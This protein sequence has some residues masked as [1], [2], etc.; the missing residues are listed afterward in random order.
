VSASFEHEVHPDVASQLAGT[1]LDPDRPLI[2]SDADE[3]IFA[4]VRGLER[5]LHRHNLYLRLESFALTGNI[6]HRHT[7]EV[8]PAEDVR[9]RLQGFFAAETHA[10]DPVE[11]VTAALDALSQ[12]AQILVL[13]NV[14]LPQR[15][16]RQEAL[17]RHGM[18]YPLVANVGAKG[19]TVAALVA[20]MAAPVFFLDD[21]PR[22][23]DSVANKAEHVTRIHFVADDRLAELIDKAERAHVRID[24]WPATRA[25]IEAD[26]AAKGY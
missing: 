6:R 2:I 22:N 16:A 1:R 23:I 19:P 20:D 26:L 18:D 25:Y 7:D 14:P 10:L 15:S 24:D 9:E 12:R 4:F 17:R 5:Y 3:V 11:G 8:L 21:I 13:S